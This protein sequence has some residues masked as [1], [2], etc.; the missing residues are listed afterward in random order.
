[1]DMNMCCIVGKFVKIEDCYDDEDTSVVTIEANIP[2]M[3]KHNINV[4]VTK[5]I[6]EEL[7]KRNLKDSFIGFKGWLAPLGYGIKFY[8]DKCSFI[9]SNTP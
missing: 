3:G 2:G 7:K 1:M 4:F 8:V 5:V 9:G 6:R